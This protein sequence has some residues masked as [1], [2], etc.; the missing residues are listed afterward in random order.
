MSIWHK[1]I[2]RV[3]G[4]LKA[5]IEVQDDYTG[6]IR[7]G[8]RDIHLEGNNYYVRADGNR[9]DVTEARDNFLRYEDKVKSALDWYN[10]TKF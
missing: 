8:L 7:G 2:L 3:D 6:N 5:Y 1:E 4:D 10:K 9:V